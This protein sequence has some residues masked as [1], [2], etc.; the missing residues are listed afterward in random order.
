MPSPL[1]SQTKS[2]GSGSPWY[3]QYAGAVQ[4]AGGGRVV[5]RGVAEAADDD[6][7]GW[8]V[9][10]DARASAARSIANATP[11]ARGRCEAIVEVCGMTASSWWPKTLCRPPAIGS[12][13]AAVTPSSMSGTPSR[14]HLR[15]RAPGRTRPTGSAAAPG[16][17]AAARARPLRSTRAPPSRSSRSSARCS[18]A[19]A[20]RSRRAGCRPARARAPRPRAAPSPPAG[21]ERNCPSRCSS[22]GSRLTA[23]D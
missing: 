11:T 18:S 7:V 9:V 19:R 16:R 6:R 1:S 2:R 23:T 15:R 21:R 22:S 8:P 3:A 5:H 17:S 10:L 13:V 20:P 12:S 14:P 4:R